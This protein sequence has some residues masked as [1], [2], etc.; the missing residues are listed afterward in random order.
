MRPVQLFSETYLEQ[1]A[2]MRPDQILRF[3][4]EFRQLQSPRRFTKSRLISIKVPVDL[5]RTFKA[6]ADL[7][8][9]PY[10]TQI[11]RLMMEWC[12]LN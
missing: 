12:S 6:R 4:D 8:D 9:I 3:L 11:K 10:Q 5:L 1:C 7:H 2:R